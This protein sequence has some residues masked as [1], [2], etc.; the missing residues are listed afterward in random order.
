MIDPLEMINIKK[1]WQTLHKESLTGILKDLKNDEII[2]ENLHL[3]VEGKGYSSRHTIKKTFNLWDTFILD[4]FMPFSE[5]METIQNV[6]MISIF[7]KQFPNYKIY[8]KEKITNVKYFK[9]HINNF[10]ENL[11]IFEQRIYQLLNLINKRA[12]QY[13][14]ENKINIKN[15]RANIFEL[16]KNIDIVRGGHVH[17]K[18]YNDDILDR[19]S[20]FDTLSTEDKNKTFI[21][22]RDFLYK[23]DRLKVSKNIAKNAIELSKILDKFLKEIYDI[24]FIDLKKILKK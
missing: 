7:V 22:L 15:L 24:C 20:L 10:L 3:S 16:F 2:K 18:F 1:F 21:F 17:K 13:N 6:Y 12:K 5:A 19:L 14:L 9:Y 23:R 11:Y 4:I 8:K